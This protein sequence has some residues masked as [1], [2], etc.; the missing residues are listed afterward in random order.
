MRLAKIWCGLIVWPKQVL[1]GVR[2]F[3][4]APHAA[5]DTSDDNTTMIV[6]QWGFSN[7]WDVEQVSGTK[8]TLVA[9]TLN[10]WIDITSPSNDGWSVW[11]D[12]QLYAD[13]LLPVIAESEAWATIEVSQSLI[14]SII[15][16]VVALLRP[17]PSA[18]S[19]IYPWDNPPAI[20][21]ICRALTIL[22]QTPLQAC[23]NVL[24]KLAPKKPVLA[25]MLPKSAPI[26][27]IQPFAPPPAF[28]GFGLPAP[29]QQ[30]QGFHQQPPPLSFGARAPQPQFD[31]NGWSQDV[32]AFTGSGTQAATV[33]LAKEFEK[34]V[35]VAGKF[36]FTVD[37]VGENIYH[38]EV[39]L[40]DFDPSSLLGRD[41]LEYSARYSRKP[42]VVLHMLFPSDFPHA[43]PFVR[44]IRP[45]FQFMTGHVTIG[46]SICTEAL[47]RSGWLPSI[48]IENVIVQIRTEIISDA[49]AQLDKRQADRPYDEHEARAAFHRMCAKYGWK[50]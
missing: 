20:L 48:A 37:L 31:S 2:S 1:S 4:V 25:S 11:S 18:V 23:A 13:A 32:Q 14:I 45:R 39:E 43:P 42:A 9:G 3:L 35:A 29:Q 8:Y 26:P 27:Q 40:I 36:G 12:T 30:H 44:V 24:R 46:G 47:T 22:T 34:C 6:F 10:F 19:P 41:I 49:R 5:M 28:M 17:F 7:G 16:L 33:A 15:T 50:G 21:L 38:W